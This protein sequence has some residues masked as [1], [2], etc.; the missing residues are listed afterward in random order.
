MY[1]RTEGTAAKS[2]NGVYMSGKM[3][4]QPLYNSVTRNKQFS[5]KYAPKTT[6]HDAQITKHVS[7]HRQRSYSAPALFDSS[8]N[9]TAYLKDATARTST[10]AG[11][12]NA[13]AVVSAQKS[14]VTHARLQVNKVESKIAQRKQMAKQRR[15]FRD[16]LQ[17]V[18]LDQVTSAKDINGNEASANR[19]IDAAKQGWRA[20]KDTAKGTVNAVR[21]YHAGR[22]ERA[23][24]R[25]LKELKKE[26]K[27]QKK[28]VQRAHKIKTRER[29]ATMTKAEI[30]RDKAMMRKAWNKRNFYRLR[31]ERQ[32]LFMSI[33]A[34]IRGIPLAIKNLPGN[35]LR[36]LRNL[37][38]MI[39]KSIGQSMLRIAF[40]VL[41]LGVIAFM[42]V[43][44]MLLP[45]FLAGGEATTSAYQTDEDTIIAV[46]HDF[47]LLEEAL[48]DSLST[49]ADEHGVVGIEVTYPGY[50]EYEVVWD[51]GGDGSGFDHNSFDLASYLNAKY[52]NYAGMDLSG[53]LQ[54]ILDNMYTI[55]TEEST[56][57]EGKSKLTV[58]IKKK[59]M[60]K[61]ARE[62][63]AGDADK[64]ALYAL[65]QETNGQYPDLFAEDLMLINNEGQRFNYYD[66]IYGE[67]NINPHNPKW[68]HV[69]GVATS[70]PFSAA[71]FNTAAPHLSTPYV[72]GGASPLGWDC[73]GFVCWTIN[74]SV[75]NVGRMTANNLRVKAT[76]AVSSS[77]A[78]PGDL[79]FFHGTTATAA[80]GNAS[81]VGIYLG[82]GYMIH[83]GSA[84]TGTS[85]VSINTNWYQSHLLGFGRLKQEYVNN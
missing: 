66:F 17:S 71:L 49:T 33:T 62:K 13:K 14:K 2:A 78:M 8:G 53:V 38:T 25:Q 60:D 15:A 65:Y 22:F 75:G 81:H 48:A 72:W 1:S 42:I 74:N 39:A 12:A 58:T 6:T 23:E 21:E 46:E 54:D 5:G 4:S 3:V 37:I 76:D 43:V 20:T 50:D 10:A 57:E 64:L 41:G 56:T 7:Q 69:Y 77:Q 36:S 40:A 27:A 82:N 34:R 29:R 16:S 26:F 28:D 55:S 32:K 59:S 35:V 80:W 51:A 79:V 31:L 11:N 18:T 73:S 70:N 84:K 30:K 68:S 61:V 44:I 52:G 63:L 19:E 83:A 85:I 67:G 47:V 45:L 24:K 9:K